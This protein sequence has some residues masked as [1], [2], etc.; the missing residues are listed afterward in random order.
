VGEHRHDAR[1]MHLGEARFID[2]FKKFFPLGRTQRMSGH[3]MDAPW[4]A[5]YALEPRGPRPALQDS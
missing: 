2:A 3:A 5:V 1:Q 4:S